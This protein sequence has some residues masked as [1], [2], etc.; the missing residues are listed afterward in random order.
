VSRAARVRRR[1]SDGW[2]ALAAGVAYAGLVPAARLDPS[3]LERRVFRFMNGTTGS[4]PPLRVPQQLGTPWLVPGLAVVGFLTHRPHLAVSAALALPVE[5]GLE[6]GVKLVFERRRPAQVLE[7]AAL[8]DDA[9]TEGG[10]YPS[11]HAAIAACAAWLV[12]PYLPTWC[13]GALGTAVGATTFTRLHQGAHVPLDAVG[14]VLM[15]VS[16]GALLTYA[17]GLPQPVTQQVTQQLTEV[18]GLTDALVHV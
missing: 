8:H 4:A 18:L 15:G 2:V 16:A 7:D 12:A 10:S 5:K 17:F 6:V 9:P 3:D 13:A 11:G 1:S 14:G